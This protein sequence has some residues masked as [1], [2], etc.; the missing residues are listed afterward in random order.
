MKIL[1]IGDTIV[2]RSYLQTKE[3]VSTGG[4]HREPYKL[5]LLRSG[6]VFEQLGG[7]MN[8]ARFLEIIGD[9]EVVYFCSDQG[10]VKDL[11]PVKERYYDLR[12]TLL[13]RI[14]KEESVWMLRQKHRMREPLYR[15]WLESLLLPNPDFDAVVISDYNKAVS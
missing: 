15:E 8:V 13:A 4:Q 6:L 1:L 5:G 11:R 14:D 12:G 9:H 3:D 7:A 2:D 10:G